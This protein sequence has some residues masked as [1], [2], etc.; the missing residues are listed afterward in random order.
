MKC[1]IINPNPK[2]LVITLNYASVE[3]G[4]MSTVPKKYAIHK[5][6]IFAHRFTRVIQDLTNHYGSIKKLST[7]QFYFSAF[8]DKI[9]SEKDK[10][11]FL[12]LLLLPL[13]S[14]SLYNYQIVKFLRGRCVPLEKVYA[15][16]LHELAI[17]INEYTKY[18]IS[19]INNDIR[20][21]IVGAR[22]E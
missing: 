18:I 6:N 7:P 16:Y 12:L 13:N 5:D 10:D 8:A 21:Y 20:V 9:I 3:D 1:T 11:L 4:I 14:Y 2:D 19:A 15:E 17:I 22:I